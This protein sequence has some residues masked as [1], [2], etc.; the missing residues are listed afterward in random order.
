MKADLERH[1]RANIYILDRRVVCCYDFMPMRPNANS[2]HT[3]PHFEAID[4]LR[5]ISILSVLLLHIRLR[6]QFSG[7]PVFPNLLIW[8]NEF[9]FKNGGHGVTIFFCISGFLITSTSIRRFGSLRS[10][11]VT[12]FY[13]L[14]FARIAPLL[15]FVVAIL[16]LLALVNAKGFQFSNNCTSVGRAAFAAFTFHINLLEAA[17]GYLPANWDILWSLSV[18]EMFYLF[19]PLLCFSL[20][21]IRNGA[22]MLV[23]VL[24]LFVILGPFSRSIWSSNVIWQNKAYLSNIDS[25]SLG[26]LTALLIEKVRS[27]QLSTRLL[28]AIHAGGLALFLWVLLWRLFYRWLG[29]AM[30]PLHHFGLDASILSIGTCFLIFATTLRSH[31]ESVYT[32]PLRALGRHSY[33]IYLS[34]EF[35]VVWSIPLFLHVNT[36]FPDMPRTL[37]LLVW[38]AGIILLAA[39]L[40]WLI[41][42][43]V[44]EPANRFLRELGQHSQAK[45]A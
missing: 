28:A 40:G 24:G 29:V 3:G 6:F 7:V 32:A 25:I 37:T 20:L 19:F 39:M 8:L 22:I 9:L 12:D 38:F 42:R 14:R 35:V 36:A 16:C 34:H 21:K 44:S 18:E 45:S 4:T 5:G 41:S 30:G 13:R 15:I 26:C 23:L 43:F 1:C 31:K 2:H 27:A 33:E 17:C 11:R 10:L